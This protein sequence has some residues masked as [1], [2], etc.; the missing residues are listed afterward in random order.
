[1]STADLFNDSELLELVELSFDLKSIN[2]LIKD[3]TQNAP[4]KTKLSKSIIGSCFDYYFKLL[5]W[6]YLYEIKNC[7]YEF[8]DW[9]IRYFEWL[10]PDRGWYFDPGYL[11][12]ELIDTFR[13][14]FRILE[15]I[16]SFNN[17][18][19]FQKYA[20]ISQTLSYL[21]ACAY[22][23]RH[24]QTIPSPSPEIS[25]ELIRLGDLIDFEKFDI[26][27]D[28]RVLFYPILSSD[29]I[30]FR[31][32]PDLFLDSTVIDIKTYDEPR[33]Q[34]RDLI[35]VL[36]YLVI[37]KNGLIN[38]HFQEEPVTRVIDVISPPIS[39]I[40]FYFSRHGYYWKA[41]LDNPEN[42]FVSEY[43]KKEL[44]KSLTKCVNRP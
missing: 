23:N 31:L 27:Q 11:N 21:R 15:D 9:G 41:N 12:N 39:D 42:E 7:N 44:I 2:R 28:T 32:F 24:Y 18:S 3:Q 8:N 20:D 19:K 34:P 16:E 36:S 35:Q 29:R 10:N 6:D 30:G 33:I 22:P 37:S 5:L 43:W 17:S 1:M 25:D 13:E 4:V 26:S 38:Y 14:T 40:G